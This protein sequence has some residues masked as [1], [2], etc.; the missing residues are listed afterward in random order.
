MLVVFLCFFDPVQHHCCACLIPGIF[1]TIPRVFFAWIYY[2]HHFH[3]LFLSFL[4]YIAEGNSMPRYYSYKLDLRRS[5]GYPWGVWL[6]PYGETTPFFFQ[7]C[8]HNWW[9]ALFSRFLSTLVPSSI[10]YKLRRVEVLTGP[11]NYAMKHTMPG[12]VVHQDC[13]CKQRPHFQTAND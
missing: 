5:V 8:K 9:I 10:F 12:D 3:T 11:V 4:L 1:I 2:L 7:Q 13:R 6:V